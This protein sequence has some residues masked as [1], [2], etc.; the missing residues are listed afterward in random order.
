MHI[1]I[2]CSHLQRYECTK[3]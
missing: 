1:C 3:W 2:N